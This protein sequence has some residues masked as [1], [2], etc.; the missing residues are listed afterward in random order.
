MEAAFIPEVNDE[1]DTQNFEKFEEVFIRLFTC[2]FC[3]T[4]R[5][6]CRHSAPFASFWIWQSECQTHTSTKTGPW[7]K[8]GLLVFYPSCWLIR[9]IGISISRALS[10]IVERKLWDSNCYSA[11]YTLLYSIF[12]F[13]NHSIKQD[14]LFHY[15]SG[16]CVLPV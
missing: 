8:V 1:L 11:E 16:E 9:Y 12:F 5:S 3:K 13:F 7:R 2:Q 10:F 14:L 15:L 4:I 6:S